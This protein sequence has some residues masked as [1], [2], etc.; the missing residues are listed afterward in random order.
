MRFSVQLSNTRMV[1]VEMVSM[2][3]FSLYHFLNKFWILNKS[4]H[5]GCDGRKWNTANESISYI[6]WIFFLV[7]WILLLPQLCVFQVWWRDNSYSLL[8]DVT[9]PSILIE[10]VALVVP[11]ET[12]SFT[13]VSTTLLWAQSKKTCFWGSDDVYNDVTSH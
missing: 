8:R 1:F 4:S 7:I 13:I 10:N 2:V 9:L 12:L 6:Q 3:S 5:V 11:Q